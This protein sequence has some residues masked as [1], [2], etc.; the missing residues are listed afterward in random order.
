MHRRQLEV[1]ELCTNDWQQ[2][3]GTSMVRHCSSCA[4]NVYNLSMLTE[5]EAVA[6]LAVRPASVCIRYNVDVGGQVIF[7]PEAPVFRRHTGPS[8]NLAAALAV[9]AMSACTPNETPKEDAPRVAAAPVSAVRPEP[10]IVRSPPA[11]HEPDRAPTPATKAVPKTAAERLSKPVKACDSRWD[12]AF[13]KNKERGSQHVS[14]HDLMIQG[15]Y[16][17]RREEAPSSAPTTPSRAELLAVLGKIEAKI[18]AEC[19]GPGVAIAEIRIAGQSG[20]ATSV[21]VAG[22]GDA[23]A[24]CIENAVRS[25]A[26]PKFE[27]PTFDVKFPFKLGGPD[28]RR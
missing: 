6:A 21:R 27:S 14:V 18:A 13:K 26:F 5:R 9:S 10:E 3:R 24:A 8:R 23:V 2:M 17:S 11:P 20:K 25:A 1:V 22:V 12:E 7:F 16:P 4:K 28:S 15:G 19:K